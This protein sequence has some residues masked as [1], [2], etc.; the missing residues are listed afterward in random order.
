MVPVT[1]SAFLFTSVPNHLFTYEQVK[2][3]NIADKFEMNKK[4]IFENFRTSF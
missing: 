1:F 2:C 4:A 3:Q